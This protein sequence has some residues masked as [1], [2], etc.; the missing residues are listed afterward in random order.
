MTLGAERTAEKR[1][2]LAELVT[3]YAVEKAGL[4]QDDVCWLMYDVPLDGM[5]FGGG[6]LLSDIDVPMP[7]VK[8]PSATVGG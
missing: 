2:K 6:K 4:G 5:S 8:Q 7:W 1:R 3:H